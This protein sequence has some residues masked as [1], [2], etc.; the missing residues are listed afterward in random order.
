M[1]RRKRRNRPDWLPMYTL[2]GDFR[3]WAWLRSDYTSYLL[4]VEP[5]GEC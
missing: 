4:Y 5:W 1:S 3:G 2:R